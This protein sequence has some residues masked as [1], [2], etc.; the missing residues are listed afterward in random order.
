MAP[1]EMI[2]NGNP[3]AHQQPATP[4]CSPGLSSPEYSR[5]SS[6]AESPSLLQS[7]QAPTIDDLEQLNSKL[8]K[9]QLSVWA[10]ESKDGESVAHELGDGEIHGS[11]EDTSVNSLPLFHRGGWELIWDTTIDLSPD[12]DQS[13]DTSSDEGFSDT[14]PDEASSETSSDGTF[15]EHD[16]AYEPYLD[17][18][19]LG[20]FDYPGLDLANN[21]I[22]QPGL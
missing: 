6:Q 14:S 10:E 20:G 17:L 22:D 18:D 13:R 7:A 12:S 16:E 8:V 1:T 19:L 3:L 2:Q 9:A 11:G 15:S 21:V 5:L 4:P